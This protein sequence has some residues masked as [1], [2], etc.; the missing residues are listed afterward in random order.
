[1]QAKTWIALLLCGAAGCCQAKFLPPAQG[2]NG[3]VV[4]ADKLAT[5]VG[6][7]I[8]KQGGN[9]IDAAVAVG[10]ALAVTHPCCG[11]IGGGGFMTI[12]LKSG[13]NIF[14]DFR[15]TAPAHI[16]RQLF[17]TDGH[18]SNKKLLHGYLGVGIPGTVLGLETARVRYGKLSRQ[19]DMAP[20][21][22]LAEKGAPLSRTSS[23][24]FARAK[25]SL[26]TIPAARKTFYHAG[27]AKAAGSWVKQPLLANTLK[28]ISSKGTD[29][30]YQGPIA[31]QIVLAS[32]QNGGVLTLEDFAHYHVISRQ[33]LSCHYQN[34]QLITAP[35]PGSGATV[36]E[37]LKVMDNYPI[38]QW[39]FHSSKTTHYNVEAMRYAFY[40]RNEKLGDPAF[41]KN[42]IKQ[43]LSPGHIAWIKSQIKAG[44]ATASAALPGQVQNHEHQQTTHYV[45]ADQDH[46]V[47]STTVTLNGF[48]GSKVMADGTGFFLNNELDDFAISTT[49]ANQF[50]LIQKTPNLLAPNKRPLSSMSPTIVLDKNGEAIMAVG[51]AGGSTI[52]TS[53]VQTIENHLAFDLDI[54]TAVNL[55]RYHMQWLPDKIYMEPL[56]F[57]QDTQVALKSMGYQLQTGFMGATKTWGQVAALTQT[58][59]MFYGANDNRRPDGLALSAGYLPRTPNQYPGNQQTRDR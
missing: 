41:I 26:E 54:N 23:E 17:K 11:N 51:A 45:V 33:P 38:K 7:D 55:P 59:A 40:D 15:E 44:N 37:I 21:I 10:Y 1:M 4:T 58:P 9:A 8:L 47:V 14:L 5:K 24:L 34:H 49:T 35:P 30:F 28:N 39:G 32:Q 19:A 50:G 48:F 36:C 42:P 31:K 22:R 16:S 12:H 6:V 52:I 53:I 46:N 2:Q 29:Y 13:K 57:S 25:K 56:A 18:Y 20:A 3:M 27:Q 43:I